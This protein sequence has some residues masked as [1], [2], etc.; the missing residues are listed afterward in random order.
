MRRARARNE[1][2]L[3]RPAGGDRPALPKD[4]GGAG[5]ARGCQR[6]PEAGGAGP[7]ASLPGAAGG[8][9]RA[10]PGSTGRAGRGARDAAWREGP[11]DAGVPA[12]R[13]AWRRAEAGRPGGGP[14]GLAPAQGPQRRPRCDRRDPGGRGRP[15]GRALRGRPLPDVLALGRCQE[16]AGRDRRRPG[17]RHR[18]LRP[19]ELRGARCRRLLAAQVRGRGAPRAAGA[20]HRVPRA[21]PYLG[22]DGG[23]DA[24]GRSG[25]DRAAREG[26]EDRDLDLHRPRWTERQHHLLGN[27][28]HPSADGHG[29]LDP[30]REVAAQEQGEGA[31]RPAHPTL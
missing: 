13:G 9:L 22:R 26:P 1:R 15:G 8:H 4:P 27:S 10:L 14:Q 3:D 11:A 20:R 30:G 31:A 2:R 24:R 5:Q 23:G 18:R 29:G 21:G 7:G 12:G 19:H 6:P 17:E 16:V 25:G 28:H